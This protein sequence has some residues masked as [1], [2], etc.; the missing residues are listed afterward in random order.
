MMTTTATTNTVCECGKAKAER[1]RKCFACLH[2]EPR[3][4]ESYIKH[5]VMGEP[6]PRFYAYRADGTNRRFARYEDAVAFIE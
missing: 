6:G 4:R 2:A 1:A 5:A 3:K